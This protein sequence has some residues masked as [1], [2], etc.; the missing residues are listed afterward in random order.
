MKFSVATMGVMTVLLILL[1]HLAV[2]MFKPDPDVRE[3]AVAC[4]VI[5]A[6]ELPAFSV[7]FTFAG[8]LR[9]A[10]DTR[11]P[12]IVALVGTFLF[13]LPLVYLL[14]IR[15]GLGLQGIWYGTLLDWIGRAVLMYLIFR[16]GK[17]KTKA[18][19]E[20]GEIAES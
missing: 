2:G 4:L 1:R 10:G 7:L 17:W 6:F 9:G 8:A 3:L 11:S 18:F 5:G 13:R 19:I 16:T 14:G 20:G 12:M 15:F